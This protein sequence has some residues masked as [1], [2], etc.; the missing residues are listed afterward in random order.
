[1]VTHKYIRDSDSPVLKNFSSIISII[2][3]S[4]FQLNLK[5]YK[6]H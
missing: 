3:N 5:Y 2:L 4:N 1:M 6:I